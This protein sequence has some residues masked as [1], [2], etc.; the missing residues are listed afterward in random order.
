MEYIYNWYL[1]CIYTYIY[2]WSINGIL[3]YFVICVF[4]YLLEYIYLL[5]LIIWNLSVHVSIKLI[6][7]E[8]I[9]FNGGACYIGK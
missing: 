7:L 8:L 9:Y 6:L 4:I 3:L 1:F 2:H 5:L